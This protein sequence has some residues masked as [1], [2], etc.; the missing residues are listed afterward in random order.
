MEHPLGLS[1]TKIVAVHLNY[2]SRAAERVVQLKGRFDRPEDMAR[3]IVDRRGGNP[4]RRAGL[5]ARGFPP[6]PLRRGG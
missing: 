1:P 2:R 4:R 5:L 6:S 3:L